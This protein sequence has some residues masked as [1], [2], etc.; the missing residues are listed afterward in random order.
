MTDC[1]GDWHENND[2]CLPNWGGFL[3]GRFR[4]RVHKEFL[5]QL[6]MFI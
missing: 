1:V 3:K 2:Q 4:P 6:Q 5:T